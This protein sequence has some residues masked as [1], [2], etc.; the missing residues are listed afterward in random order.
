MS[1]CVRETER[2]RE[3]E[4]KRERRESFHLFIGKEKAPG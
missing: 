1:L 2:G 3:G 4:G